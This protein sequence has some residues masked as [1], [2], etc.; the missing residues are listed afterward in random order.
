MDSSSLTPAKRITRSKVGPQDPSVAHKLSSQGQGIEVPP[1]PGQ[2]QTGSTGTIKAA[3]RKGV[4]PEYA[5]LDNVGYTIDS[6]IWQFYVDAI[7]SF[8]WQFYVD[9]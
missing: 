8:I 9:A 1:Q 7:N 3:D 6:F 2:P 5:S 4:H